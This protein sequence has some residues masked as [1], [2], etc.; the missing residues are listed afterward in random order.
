MN[1]YWFKRKRYGYGFVPVT[2]QG[3]A[4][5]GIYLLVIFGGLLSIRDMPEDDF[6][7]E[8]SI[9][10]LVVLI[11]TSA[12]IIVSYKH[13]PTLKWRWGKSDRDNPDE[14]F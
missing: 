6:S 3:W 5:I 7:A 1:N 11:A 8:A 13:G 2:W 10:L 4:S 14:D 12:L 9:Y